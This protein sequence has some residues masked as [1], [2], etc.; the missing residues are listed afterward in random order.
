MQIINIIILIS[1]NT[2]ILNH[3]TSLAPLNS[4]H[5]IKIKK[6]IDSTIRC[7]SVCVEFSILKTGQ[8][9]STTPCDT[10]HQDKNDNDSEDRFLY[11]K[12]IYKFIMFSQFH[13]CSR[14]L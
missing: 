8:H 5:I 13:S 11:S 3:A 12:F 4:F 14:F 1:H 7:L 10:I 9:I 6:N 2:N